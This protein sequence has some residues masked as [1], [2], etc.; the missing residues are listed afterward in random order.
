MT[1]VLCWD[2]DGTL[3]STARAGIFAW[4]DATRD[5][6]GQT[7]DFSALATAGLTDT[8]IAARI[9]ARFDPDPTP[10]AVGV[11]VRRYEALLPDRLHRRVGYGLDHYFER[12]AFAD[13]VR[14]RGAIAR[15]AVVV[16]REL[17]GQEPRMEDTYVI[18]DTPHDIMCAR[19]IGARAVAVASG[20]YGLADLEPH[21]PWWLIRVEASGALGARPHRRVPRLG[22]QRG[23][24]PEPVGRSARSRAGGT[25]RAD[26]DRRRREPQRRQPGESSGRGPHPPGGGGAHPALRPRAASLRADRNHVVSRPSTVCARRPAGG[27]VQRLLRTRPTRA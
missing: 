27:S 18:G 2:I 17:L 7:V 23:S 1:L 6:V 4:E 3:L 11:L 9:L 14:D 15:R 26:R 24:G 16:A 8:E 10:T 20:S 5:I 12:G 22:G 25:P 19:A 21:D 13:G